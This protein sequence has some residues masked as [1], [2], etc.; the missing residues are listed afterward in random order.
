MSGKYKK[1][2]IY[3]NHVEHLL[4]QL[5]QFIGFVSI[6]EFALLVCFS[7]GISSLVVRIKICAIPAWIKKFKSITKNNNKKHDKIVLLR[8][9]KVILLKF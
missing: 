8:K 7:V 2:C 4:M 1:K 5:Q 6:S 9:D 3:L